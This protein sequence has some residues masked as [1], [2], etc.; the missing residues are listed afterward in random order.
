MAATLTAMRGIG[1]H[2]QAVNWRWRPASVICLPSVL[3]MQAALSLRFIWSNTAFMD[4]A[5]YLRSGHMEIAHW[6]H[7][8]PLQAGYP[9]QT[10][11]SGSPVV[12]PPIGAIADSVGGLAGARLL[13]LAFMLG[14]TGFLYAAALRLFDRQVAIAAA[15]V[16]IILGP[17]QAL[18]ALATY[19][20][21]SVFLT[22]LAAWLVVRA[23][24]RASE[25]LIAL[26][27]LVM[28]IADAGKY[29]SALWDPAIIALAVVTAGHA[30]WM[31]STARGIRLALYLAVILAGALFWGGHSYIKGIE[32]TT[33]ARTTGTTP[34]V[35]V[36]EYAFGLIGIVLLLA[37]LGCIISFRRSWRDRLTCLIL[38]LTGAAVLAPVQEARIHT[39]ISLYKHV[40]FGAWFGAMAAGY[41]LVQILRSFQTKDGRTWYTVT[42]IAA[43]IMIT[44]ELIYVVVGITAFSGFVQATALSDQ[45]P[46]QAQTVKAILTVM[47]K[48][49][50]PCLMTENEVFSYYLPGE[51]PDP[52][53]TCAGAYGFGFWSTVQQRYISGIPAYVTAI[54]AH[55]FTVI[56]IDQHELDPFYAPVAAAAAASNYTL[57]SSVPDSIGSQPI[58]VWCYEPRRILAGF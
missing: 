44:G 51:I 48:E 40:V 37:S 30:G 2:R 1:N 21:M 43:A 52:D 55:H 20:A 36:L 13:S 15:A 32:Y 3:V 14:A 46:D 54:H 49:H 50:G 25:P 29:A 34:P 56:E 5:L 22:A 4:E 28:A 26:S 35:Q 7:N 23:E 24:G 19:D 31:R 45:W 58:E 41:A 10:Y 39:L 16:F 8:A 17:T 27:A 47:Q 42:P 6:L 9:F 33:L 11:F 12:Y 18:G 38:I 53:T 57:I